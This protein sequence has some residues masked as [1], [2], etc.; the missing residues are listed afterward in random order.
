MLINSNSGYSDAQYFS[1]AGNSRTGAGKIEKGFWLAEYQ[2]FTDMTALES[3]TV[4]EI[5]IWL[6]HR[7]HADSGYLR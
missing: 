4:F 5:Y 1:V 6:F 3:T 2:Q 7:K